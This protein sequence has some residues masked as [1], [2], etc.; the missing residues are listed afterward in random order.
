[1]IFHVNT[2]IK[3]RNTIIC[4]TKYFNTL[5]LFGPSGF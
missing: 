1:M 3:T 4:V 2:N 5:R